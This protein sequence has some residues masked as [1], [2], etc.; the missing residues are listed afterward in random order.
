M[1]KTTGE[2]VEEMPDNGKE[3]LAE[4][5]PRFSGDAATVTTWKEGRE[6]L[7]K[8][9]ATPALPEDWR[10]YLKQRLDAAPVP[11]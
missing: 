2:R 9:I 4:L 6:L 5:Q 7:E 3:P 8:A 1:S 11:S 10:E